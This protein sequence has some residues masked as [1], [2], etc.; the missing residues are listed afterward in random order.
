MAAASEFTG[1]DRSQTPDAEA[2]LPTPSEVPPWMAAGVPAG[3]GQRAEDP[4]C[5]GSV[6][7][8]RWVLT[9]GHCQAS[10]VGSGVHVAV[11]TGRR[12]LTKGQI[13]QYLTVDRAV[14]MPGWQQ[15][16]IGYRNDFTLLHLTRPTTAP[17]VAVASPHMAIQFSYGTHVRAAGWGALSPDGDPVTL[18]HSTR[19]ER[20]PNAVCAQEY[21]KL[22]DARTQLC[23]GWKWPS[24]DHDTCNGDSGGPMALKIRGS[25]VEVAVTSW[26]S[27]CLTEGVPG[28]YADVAPAYAWITRVISSG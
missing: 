10:A 6:I 24:M 22:F 11:I 26:G 1:E 16:G 25:V 5:S 20:L 23:G 15:Q 27:T 19:L 14:R 9:A 17:E 28:V 21:G 2:S 18:L 4:A 13:G 3:D 8:S 7:A 12:D